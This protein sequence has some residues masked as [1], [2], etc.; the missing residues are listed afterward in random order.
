LFIGSLLFFVLAFSLLH[1]LTDVDAAEFL[2]EV[3]ALAGMK[4]PHTT[5]TKVLFT[6]EWQC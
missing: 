2:A 5:Q 6:A 3:F 1:R 4:Q